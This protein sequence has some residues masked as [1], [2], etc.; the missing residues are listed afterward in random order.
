MKWYA[1]VGLSKDQ[2]CRNCLTISLISTLLMLGWW[3]WLMP[4]AICIRCWFNEKIKIN[5]KPFVHDIGNKQNKRW[6]ISNYE[7][8]HSFIHHQIFFPKRQMRNFSQKFN[9]YRLV[10]IWPFHSFRY[11]S[12]AVLNRSSLITFLFFFWFVLM[13]LV[14][15][16][17]HHHF[18]VLL[19][20]MF[21]VFLLF[22]C[23]K[24]N[25]YPSAIVKVSFFCFCFI[26]DPMCFISPLCTF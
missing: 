13:H 22:C 18:P 7:M 26:T 24:N 3:L 17:Y 6:S 5:T 23:F 21:L 11:H 15:F 25:H 9:K 12:P 4:G 16:Y 1:F 19:W 2:Y 10:G 8:K 14:L 20:S